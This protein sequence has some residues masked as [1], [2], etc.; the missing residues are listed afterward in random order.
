MNYLPS[1]EIVSFYTGVMSLCLGIISFMASLF[2]YDKAKDSENKN[3]E[4]LTEIKLTTTTLAT[5]TNR[6]LEKT[7]DNI[8]STHNKLIDQI[9]NLQFGIIPHD[10]KID[11]NISIK[12]MLFS[13]TIKALF[14]AVSISIFVKDKA[15]IKV[16]DII[17]EQGRKDYTKLKNDI[18]NIDENE[19]KKSPNYKLYISDRNSF[20]EIL[21]SQSTGK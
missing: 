14:L 12:L 6:T 3:N 20:E 15:M 16:A 2:F 21:Q 13:Y 17:I 9:I 7:I 4:I 8:S 10:S 1:F 5:I 11:D 19:L 18:D